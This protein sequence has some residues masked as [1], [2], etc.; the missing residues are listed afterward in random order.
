MSF[1]II[2]IKLTLYL[3]L[4]INYIERYFKVTKDHL[5]QVLINKELKGIVIFLDK[6]AQI[7]LNWD[8]QYNKIP[9]Q[10]P[11]QYKMIKVNLIILS[12]RL[13]S[14]L[15]QFITELRNLFKVNNQ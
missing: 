7:Q 4:L 13:K 10:Q 15:L 6:V 12:T 2:L 11:I 3:F 1:Q 5:V 8:N 14:R 9:V